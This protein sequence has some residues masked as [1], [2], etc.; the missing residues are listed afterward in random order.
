MTVARQVFCL[1]QLRGDVL[2]L[3]AQACAFAGGRVNAE[4]PLPR[5]HDV[6]LTWTAFSNITY[7][8]QYNP[9]LNPSNWSALPGDVTSMSNFASKLDPLYRQ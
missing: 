8:V 6:L 4:N 2:V 3:G 5:F 1:Y 9:N 7:R